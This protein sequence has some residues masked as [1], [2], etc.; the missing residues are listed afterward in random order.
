MMAQIDAIICILLSQ[1]IS[2]FVNLNFLVN[3][4]NLFPF[5]YVYL[6]IG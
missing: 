6:N 4:V 1:D 5:A 2:L 3:F